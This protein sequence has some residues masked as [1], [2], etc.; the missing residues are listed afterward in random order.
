MI[1][2]LVLVTDRSLAP[3]GD[4]PAVVRATLRGGADCVHLR[5]RGLPDAQLL[6]LAQALRAETARAGARFVVNHRV[7]LA[8]AA[9]ADGVHLG[10]RSMGPAEARRAAGGAMSV[11]VSCHSAVEARAAVDDGAD[12]IF[13]GPVFETP[14]KEGLADP[15]GLNAFGKICAVVPLPVVGIGG[16]DA[17]RAAQVVRAGACGV[18]VI[19]DIMA[20][21]DPEA[22][23]KALIEGVKAAL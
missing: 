22:A 2:R 8:V 4:L 10:W 7:D 9:D 13:L 11:G 23:A 20:A 17:G 15:L 12:Y 21:E 6:A 3:G 5:E 18:A 1:S 14:S 16:I 19:R